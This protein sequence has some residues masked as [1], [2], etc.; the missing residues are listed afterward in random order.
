M[1]KKI[2]LILSLILLVL[3][4][5]SAV[6]LIYFYNNRSSIDVSTEEDKLETEESNISEFSEDIIESNTE[7]EKED[8]NYLNLEQS[9]E[10]KKQ[11]SN[12]IED[13]VENCGT[14]EFFNTNV[15]RSGEKVTDPSFACFGKNIL[16]DCKES[17]LFSKDFNMGDVVFKIKK[18][19]GKCFL[20]TEYG[21]E[22]KIVNQ[23]D[24]IIANKYMKCSIDVIND[25]FLYKNLGSFH[26]LEELF[27]SANDNPTTYSIYLI[28]Y[29]DFMLLSLLEGPRSD[30]KE[31]IESIKKECSGPA[32]YEYLKYI[33][34][35]NQ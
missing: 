7:G 25:V 28:I 32:F 26:T 33:E 24:K 22:D 30:K 19:E 29:Q 35:N 31:L 12:D 14:T 11:R 27:I 17:I 16:N 20:I 21:D 34:I 13:G 23:V 1:N 5:I 2:L 4:V 15:L 18:E 3:G 6:A 9:K 8:S 10:D